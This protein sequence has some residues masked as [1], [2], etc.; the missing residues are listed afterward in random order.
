MRE[1]SYKESL[2][3]WRVEYAPE[4]TVFEQ[5]VQEA[6]P[7]IKWKRATI[8]EV[9]LDDEAKGIVFLSMSPRSVK[10]N[11]HVVCEWEAAG[12]QRKCLLYVWKPPGKRR[13]SDYACLR[14]KNKI[15]VRVIARA[16]NK[17][18]CDERKR[19]AV[20]KKYASN[21]QVLWAGEDNEPG[22]SFK[23]WTEYELCEG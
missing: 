2:K 5:F 7:E 4:V 1:L 18:G 6:F 23:E 11:L 16:F 3:L 10:L 19:V 13:L 22:V 12:K 21:K 8:D 20:L 15:H 9:D 14:R 17:P